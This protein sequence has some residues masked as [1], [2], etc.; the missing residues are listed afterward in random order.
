MTDRVNMSDRKAMFALGAM[1]KASGHNLSEL[2][3]SRSSIR[4]YR[5]R[6]RELAVTAAKHHNITETMPLL[7]HW[8]TKLLPGL[9]QMEKLTESPSC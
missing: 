1:A 6:N 5:I 3:L 7:L 4:R 2:T 9:T 8:D